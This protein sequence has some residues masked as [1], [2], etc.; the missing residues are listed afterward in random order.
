M[1]K[2]IISPSIY[3]DKHDQMYSR[4]DLNWYKYVDK[5]NFLLQKIPIQKNYTLN[6]NHKLAGI[7]FS[8]GN[9]LFNLKKKKENLIR[10][11]FEKKLFKLIN[12]LNIPA[13]FICRGMQ[14]LAKMENL[15]LVKVKNHIEKKQSIFLL[16]KKM[17][18]VNSFHNYAIF[19]INK[20][21]DVIA[22]HKDGSIEIMKHKKKKYLCMMFHPERK[23]NDHKFVDDMIKKFFKLK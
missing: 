23:L 21:Y 22:T 13:L 18:S 10:D 9:D 3:I 5:L 15:K 19:N 4:V 2:I 20:N 17:L 7:I 14:F 11:N 12:K 16:N 8:G 1:K 6:K